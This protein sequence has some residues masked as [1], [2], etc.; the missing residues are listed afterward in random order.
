MLESTFALPSENP[1]APIVE[2]VGFT[3]KSICCNASDIVGT[4]LT[5]ALEADL[6]NTRIAPATATS[7][8]KPMIIILE[9][10]IFV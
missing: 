1:I 2:L 4:L 6:L 7:N 8:T 5:L 10:T 9:F 3:G